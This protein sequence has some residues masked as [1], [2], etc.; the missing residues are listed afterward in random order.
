MLDSVCGKAAGPD[1]LPPELVKFGGGALSRSLYA[2]FLK[3]TMRLDEA[4]QWK[5]GIIHHAWKGK[6]SPED[7]DSHR[8]LLVSS[9]IGKSMHSV[10]RRCCV[11]PM[12]RTS[13]ALQVGGL[14]A[15][16]VAFAAHCVR[17]FQSMCRGST[18][19]LLFLDLKEAF[20]RVYRALL[21]PE[22]PT[23]EEVAY[24]FKQLGLP[25]SAFD[26]FR[27]A[28]STASALEAAG[29]SQW[30]RAVLKEI[31]SDTWFKL[32]GQTDAVCT[33]L[34]VRPGDALADALFFFL[35]AQVLKETRQT[36]QE[37]GL[38]CAL[39]WHRGMSGCV[40]PWQGI[41]D[42]SLDLCDSVW[43]DDACLM[44]RPVNAVSAVGALAH[45]AGALIDACLRR[46]LRPSLSVNKTEAMLS[47]KGKG[48][49]IVRQEHLSSLD[50]IRALA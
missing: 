41:A 31:L 23:D 25:P 24:M 7:C 38:L 48:S 46:G 14:P 9:V 19:F 35:F 29:S 50:P 22:A 15:Y 44:V 36:L 39:P 47:V 10:I 11:G 34:G 26:Q 21:H 27:S 17:L 5:G 28:A 42:S 40:L 6:Q 30:L 37:E 20:Y 49:R 33:S 2:L 45:T 3:M 32:Q 4:M 8:A 18:C 1:H 43:M 12:R 13:T 16:P